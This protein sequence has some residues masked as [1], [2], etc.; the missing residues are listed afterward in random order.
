MTIFSENVNVEQSITYYSYIICSNLMF[1]SFIYSFPSLPLRQ[2]LS[3]CVKLTTTKK[4][5]KKIKRITSPPQT[6]YPPPPK[7]ITIAFYV[8]ETHH[9]RRKK[10]IRKSHHSKSTIPITH[11]QSQ[12]QNPPANLDA[13]HTNLGLHQPISSYV[14]LHGEG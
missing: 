14:D 3:L 11:S 13:H 12:L 10:I 8:S 4:Q 6:H 9:H 7:S 2:S 5:K 1:Y